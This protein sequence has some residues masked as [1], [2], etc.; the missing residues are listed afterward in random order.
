MNKSTDL[1]FSTPNSIRGRFVRLLSLVGVSLYCTACPTDGEGIQACGDGGLDPAEQCDDGNAYSGDGCTPYCQLEPEYTCP[2]ASEPCV[3]EPWCGD[4]VVSAGE[5]CDDGN[6]YSGD[7]CDA[8]CQ[9][10]V[11]FACHEGRCAPVCADGILTA[12][13]E[14][15]DG[16]TYDGDGCTAHCQVEPGFTCPTSGAPCEPT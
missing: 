8:G 5:E 16:N 10:E 2:D 14:C 1:S 6:T 15:D 12:A 7:G 3:V 4:G 9:I 13:E 11:G